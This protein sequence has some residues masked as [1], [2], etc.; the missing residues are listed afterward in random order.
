MEIS[1]KSVVNKQEIKSEVEALRSQIKQRQSEID[2]LKHA[3]QHY[4]KQCD[5]AGQVTGSNERDGC[6][7]NPCPTCGYSY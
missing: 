6:W 1:L 3:I 4:Q 7:G 2:L 5:H